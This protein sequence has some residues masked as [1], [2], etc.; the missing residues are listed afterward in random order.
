[1]K[2]FVCRKDP[3][4]DIHYTKTNEYDIICTRDHG[5]KFQDILGS[6]L[7]AS[8]CIMGELSKWFNCRT[9]F[10]LQAISIYGQDKY[11]TL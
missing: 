10:Y 9:K 7:P 11:L 4:H 8:C 2:R 6:K 1:M 3:K 5:F